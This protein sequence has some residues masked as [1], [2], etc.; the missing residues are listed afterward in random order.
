MPRITHFQ[1]HWSTDDEFK[2]S[3]KKW[4]NDDFFI[5]NKQSVF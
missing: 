4:Q 3:V 1:D 2:Q 5:E